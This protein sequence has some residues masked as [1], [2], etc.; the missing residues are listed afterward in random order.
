M[1]IIEFQLYV[2]SYADTY[3]IDIVAVDEV[4]AR[5]IFDQWLYENYKIETMWTKATINREVRTRN[6]YGYS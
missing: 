4:Q 3:F 1:N 5:A 2:C 6:V